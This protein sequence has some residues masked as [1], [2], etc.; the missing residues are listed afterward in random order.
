MTI[1]NSWTGLG[2]LGSD[3]ELEYTPGG[4]LIGKV[5]VATKR[6]GKDEE[7]KYTN[8]TEWIRLKF[9]GN[10]AER[11]NNFG[12]CKGSKVLIVGYLHTY[13]WTN[14]EGVKQ[15]SW[16]IVVE[17]FEF[18]GGEKNESQSGGAVASVESN[19]VADDE[20]DFPF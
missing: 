12:L 8:I 6:R 15:Y 2:N 7:G 17:D 5:S 4:T 10:T 1:N 14:S 9:I 19:V 13:S 11:A 18:V 20:D 3:M 16:E